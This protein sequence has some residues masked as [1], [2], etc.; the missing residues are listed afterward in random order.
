[1]CTK[2][3]TTW[4]EYFK[5]E[6][7]RDEIAKDI[8]RTHSNFH[9][10]AQKPLDDPDEVLPPKYAK[11]SKKIES[12]LLFSP[13]SDIKSETIQIL[14]DELTSNKPA[15]FF[16]DSHLRT[17]SV[18]LSNVASPKVTIISSPEK[19]C[20]AP[21][22]GDHAGS[23]ARILFIFAKLNPGIRYVQGMNEILAPIYYVFC[24]ERELVEHPE[25]CQEYAEPDAFFCFTQIMADLRDR[26]LKS[27]DKSSD[28]I[29]AAVENL[30]KLLQ[31]ID[32]V[33]HS[34]LMVHGIDPRLYAFRWMSL[35][36]SQEFDI[37]DVIRFWDA[38][39]ADPKREDGFIF[40]NYVCVS[41][42]ITVRSTLLAGDFSEIIHCLQHYPL[43]GLD[44]EAIISRAAE[45]YSQ[46]EL[47]L[48]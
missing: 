17:C 14:L 40:L 41:M 11:E 37:P 48:L 28:G 43:S 44:I 29:M 26:F 45:L 6:V 20:I 46:F 34:H 47:T 19:Q 1:M 25:K 2:K 31:Q 32:P 4:T 10:F 27:L 23:L 13:V 35:L 12:K 33:L 16:K 3:N 21:A 30:H 24:Q 5:D 36:L 7:I 18:T 38:L 8:R 42:I 39:F 22:P 9:F 15:S